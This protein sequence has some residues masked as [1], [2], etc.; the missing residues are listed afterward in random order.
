[1]RLS[2][3]KKSGG[4]DRRGKDDGGRRVWVEKMQIFEGRKRQKKVW[5]RVLRRL[6]RER[7]P[8]EETEKE[9]GVFVARCG[10]YVSIL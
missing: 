9:V 10:I 4:F 2:R 5:M 3:E 6:E 8:R 7:E 1:M